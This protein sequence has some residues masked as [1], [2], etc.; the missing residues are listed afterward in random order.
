M[1]KIHR[2]SG[3]IQCGMRWAWSGVLLQRVAE[4][5]QRPFFNARYITA[6][7]AE[8]FCNL[9]LRQRCCHAETVPESYDFPLTRG[10]RGGESAMH[11]KIAVVFFYCGKPVILAADDILQSQRIAVAVG[12]ERV[13]Q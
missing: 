5:F 9:T 2:M 13:G 3:L 12:F 4:L 11:G 1:H 6:R 10:K 8:A 7:D